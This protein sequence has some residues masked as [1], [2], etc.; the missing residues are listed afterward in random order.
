[1]TEGTGQT[2]LAGIV[3]SLSIG[4]TVWLMFGDPWPGAALALIGVVVATVLRG[5]GFTNRSA[6]Y[7]P[8]LFYM[9]ALIL[10][11]GMGFNMWSG[12]RRGQITP[13]QEL[14]YTFTTRAPVP[15]TAGRRPH[16]YVTFFPQAFLYRQHRF[17]RI[18]TTFDDAG[19][20]LAPSW[21]QTMV[22]EALQ[23][24]VRDIASC[25]TASARLPGYTAVRIR[26]PPAEVAVL[27]ADGSVRAWC[28]RHE[29]GPPEGR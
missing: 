21:P 23:I 29:I 10:P 27:D 1:M 8:A 22:Y 16:L 9:M 11:V 24:P 14:Q 28:E 20:Y 13:W 5:V 15:A 18:F 7:P 19:I 12:G 17:R 25:D 2:W 4:F 6:R 3:F 26:Y